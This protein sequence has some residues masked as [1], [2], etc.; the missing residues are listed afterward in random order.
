MP[1]D[2]IIPRQL[3]SDEDERLVEQGQ[4]TDAENV[5][6]SENGKGTQSIVKNCK[7]TIPGTPLNSKQALANGAKLV[8]IGSV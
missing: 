6:I 7:G 1:V 4:M 8:V 2:K 5:T 3:N